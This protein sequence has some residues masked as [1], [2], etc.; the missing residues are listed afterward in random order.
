MIL[1]FLSDFVETTTIMRFTMGSLA[2]IGYGWMLPVAATSLALLG[3]VWLRR[4]ELQLLGISDESAQLKGVDTRR[5]SLELL[6]TASL[7][8]G[9][10]VSVTGPIG[11]VGLIIPH[12][13][14]L[15]YRRSVERLIAPT[16]VLGGLF[17]VAA[18]AFARLIGGGSEI[19]ISIITSL[20][21]GPFFIYLILKSRD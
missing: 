18:D 20:V 11:F 2:T 4:F 5:L 17:L 19:P 16:F 12:I 9:T 15:L 13:A 14:R 1:Y 21:G 8:V 7:A 10:L 6:L 3:V